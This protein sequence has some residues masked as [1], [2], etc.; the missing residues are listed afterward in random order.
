MVGKQNRFCRYLDR[1]PNITEPV[2]YP[3]TGQWI[4]EILKGIA[5]T[6]YGINNL[7]N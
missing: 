7:V 1:K 5:T 2:I 4:F 6:I 3:H